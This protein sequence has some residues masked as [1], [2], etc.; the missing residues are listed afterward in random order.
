MIVSASENSPPAPRPCT[1]R[2]AA[3]CHIDSA[4]PHS[5]EPTTK[6]LIAARKN[7]RRP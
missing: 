5:A 7:G 2:N 1:A 6:M 3:S 4:R